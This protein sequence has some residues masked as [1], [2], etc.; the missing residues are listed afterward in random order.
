ML[1]AKP[2]R[3]QISVSFDPD[4]LKAL[5]DFCEKRGETVGAFIRFATLQ[6]AAALGLFSP[7]RRKVFGG[8]A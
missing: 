8:Q 6:R 5:E 7:E 2:L 1:R 4:D 3:G